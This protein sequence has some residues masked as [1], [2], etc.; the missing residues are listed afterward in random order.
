[1]LLVGSNGVGS[2]LLVESEVEE[3]F[4]LVLLGGDG[5]L[6]GG[7]DDLGH[8]PGIRVTVR[9]EGSNRDFKDVDVDVAGSG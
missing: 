3:A 4:R 2:R 5:P 6:V 9:V 7:E 8:S 1:M